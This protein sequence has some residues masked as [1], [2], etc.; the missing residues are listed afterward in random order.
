[1]FKSDKLDSVFFNS[2]PTP[3]DF[4]EFDF[5]T[6]DILDKGKIF[7]KIL[8]DIRKQKASPRGQS[9]EID[10]LI[11]GPKEVKEVLDLFE[12]DLK[13]SLKLK[14]ITYKFSQDLKIEISTKT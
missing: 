2:Y 12:L 14:T 8:E 9:N 6:Q 5:I 7:E 10:V 3:S 1:M 11:S 13:N 4:K